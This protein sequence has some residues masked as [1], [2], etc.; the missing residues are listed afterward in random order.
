MDL[1]PLGRAALAAREGCR[2][3]AYRDSVGVW[4]IGRGHTSAA[5]QVTGLRP[6]ADPA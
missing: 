6:E 4:I 2:L 1:G 3:R 5:G